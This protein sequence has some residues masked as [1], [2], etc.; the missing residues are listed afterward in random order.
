[1]TFAFIERAAAEPFAVDGA[2]AALANPLS[3]KF[4]VLRPSLLPGLVDAAAHNRRRERRDVRLF[5][6]GARFTADG[7]R[8]AS[9]ACG[10]APASRRTG[11]AR[12]AP[13]I[14]TTSRASRRRCSARLARSDR[15]RACWT[16]RTSLTAV[17]RR[18]WQRRAEAPER[19]S[20]KSARLRRTSP[21]RAASPAP[22]RS[23]RSSSMSRPWR[24]ASRDGDLR[25]VP[26]PRFPSIVARSLDPGRCQ[27]A[28]GHGSWHYPCGGTFDAAVDR[29]VRSLSR[30]RGAGRPR[31]PLA[32]SHVPLTRT[33]ADRRRGGRGHERNRDGACVRA[34]G[35]TQ[36]RRVIE[37]RKNRSLYGES[38]GGDAIGRARVDRQAGREGPGA[39]RGARTDEDGHGAAER[40]KHEAQVRPVAQRTKR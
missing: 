2:P 8:R 28:C 3:E 20:V 29:G 19:G 22:S 9:Q 26:L 38:G 40:G 5:E 37:E 18:S 6:S 13:R 32:A 14:S 16:G 12:R 15:V 36:E 17:R 7:E 24:H 35:R 1:M 23:S 11:R 27:L 34:P 10:P 33:D 31:E 30:Q 21:R 39:R 25:V 4:A